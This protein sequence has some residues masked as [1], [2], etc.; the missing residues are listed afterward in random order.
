ML[1]SN[2]FR[3]S[4]HTGN[5]GSFIKNNVLY[6]TKFARP[7]DYRFYYVISPIYHNYRC[8]TVPALQLIPII[9]SR[10]GNKPLLT[11][12]MPESRITN[13]YANGNG[14]A[15]GTGTGF[16]EARLA[17]GET[18]LFTSESVGEGHPGTFH[19]R[20]IFDNCQRCEFHIIVL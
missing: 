15:S 8:N 3:F 18:F 20:S 11:T 9:N 14:N 2:P 10:R 12:T 16:P 4:S 5:I 7:Q 6:F 17:E 19:I 1:F 13:G